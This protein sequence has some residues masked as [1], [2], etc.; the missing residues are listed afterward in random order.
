[1]PRLFTNELRVGGAA[2]WLLDVRAGV[3][4]RERPAGFICARSEAH[5]RRLPRRR[6]AAGRR[7]SET[8]LGTG[9]ENKT[10]VVTDN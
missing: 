8:P 3:T 5:C 10:L 2:G 6:P 4:S 1:M 9:E 7:R